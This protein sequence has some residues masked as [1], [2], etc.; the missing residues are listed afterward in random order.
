MVSLLVSVFSIVMFF[1]SL[2]WA[3]YVGAGSVLAA[4]IA[5]AFHS[6]LR[7]YAFAAWVVAVVMIAIW[8]PNRFLQLGPIKG[9]DTLTYLIQIAMFGMGATLTHTDFVRVLKMPKGIILGIVLQ[10]SMMPLLGWSVAKV[11]RLPPEIAVGVILVGSCPG[12]VSSNVITYLAKGNVA[13]SVTMTACTTLAS[14]V[15]TTFLMYLLAGHSISIDYFDMFRNIC[16]TV[17]APVVAGLLFNACIQRFKLGGA[18]M[19]RYLALLAM[20]AICLICGIIAANSSKDMQ[21]VGPV[22]LVAVLM[23]N[24]CGY[25]LGYGGAK[26]FRLNE[27]DSRTIAI[28]VGLQNGGMAAMLATK[29]LKL[30]TAAIAPAIFAPVMNVTGSLLAAW[31]GRTTSETKS[32][33]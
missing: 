14:P 23:H 3:R 16:L 29:V 28:E 2:D 33:P 1:Y 31:W 8:F 17:F 22:L 18:T 19:D 10:Y 20:V 9:V 15:M 32:L 27:A 30:S 4:T 24:L 12:G 25:L 13:L 26:L 21:Q 5:I 6:T 11:L 7:A